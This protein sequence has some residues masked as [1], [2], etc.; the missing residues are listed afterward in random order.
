[1]KLTL[2]LN[3]KEQII[4]HC[5]TPKYC[6]IQSKDDGTITFCIQFRR[7]FWIIEMVLS[8][9]VILFESLL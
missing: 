1:M 7:Y 9:N 4:V 3:R 8:P 2:M 5:R 6:F